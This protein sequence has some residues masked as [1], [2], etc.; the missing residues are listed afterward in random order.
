MPWLQE[1]KHLFHRPLKA[2]TKTAACDIVLL[3][4]IVDVF[5]LILRKLISLLHDALSFLE[6]PLSNTNKGLLIPQKILKPI[7]DLLLLSNRLI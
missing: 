2:L 3:S 7:N 6:I 4:L 5:Q 1:K